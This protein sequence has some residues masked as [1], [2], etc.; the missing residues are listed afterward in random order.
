MEGK[1]MSG[2]KVDFVNCIISGYSIN[3]ICFA[4]PLYTKSFSVK[5]LGIGTIP[6]MAYPNT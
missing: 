6:G 5:C 3:S 4:Y 2:I 1:A